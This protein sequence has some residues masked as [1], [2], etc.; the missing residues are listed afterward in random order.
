MD[1]TPK[2]QPKWATRALKGVSRPRPVPPPREAKRTNYIRIDKGKKRCAACIT[3]ENSV[4]QTELTYRNTRKVIEFLAPELEE[5]GEYRAVLEST[6][7]LW[8]KTYEVL[9]AHGVPV[10]LTNPLKTR[11]IAEARIKTDRHTARTLAH[12]LRADLIP[13]CT[14]IYVKTFKSLSARAAALL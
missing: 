4:I 5:R 7:N 10:K 13:E 8:F 2:R 6:G 3:D 12:L 9:E 14:R 11:A 1:E